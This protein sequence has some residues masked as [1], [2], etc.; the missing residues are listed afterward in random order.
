[1]KNII[2]HN[3]NIQEVNIAVIEEFENM[4]SANL[5]HD[6]KKFLLEYN[7]GYP[8]KNAFDWVQKNAIYENVV[9][10][11]DIRYFTSIQQSILDYEYLRERMPNEFVQIADDNFSNRICLGIKGSYYGKVYFWDHDW[12]AED[13]E[14]PTY[15]NLSL[16][17][18][19]FTDFINML[20][21]S[22]FKAL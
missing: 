4:I 19:S 10:G 16:I 15:D 3:D 22:D 21:F 9:G 12:E 17:A 1:M 2:I 6:Y 14:P 20:F 5:C 7:G 18:N 8:E 11:D 13:D